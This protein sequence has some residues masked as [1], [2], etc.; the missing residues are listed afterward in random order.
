[1]F[2]GSY[3]VVWMVVGL[4]VYVVHR[5]HGSDVAGVL[6]IAA[7]VYEPTP[8]KRERRRRCQAGVRLGSQLGR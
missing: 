6:T 5:P 4:V 1:M 8:L 2:A 7:G 3:L